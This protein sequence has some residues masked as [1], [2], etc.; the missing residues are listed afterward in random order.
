MRAGHAARADVDAQH[1]YNAGPVTRERI[2][3]ALKATI[4]KADL[5]VVDLDRNYFADHALTIARHPSET[6][7]RM[8]VRVLAFALFAREGLTFTKGLFD[9]DEP[10]LWARNLS[11]EIELWIDLGQPDE[12]RIRRACSRAAHVV[13]LCY[14]GSCDTWWKSVAG[15]LA[16]LTNLNVVQLPAATADALAALAERGMRLQCMIQD[17]DVWLS[18]DQASVQVKRTILKPTD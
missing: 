17:G 12:A 3:M 14:A 9:V 13:V 7:A 10:E 11:G 8:M 2:A 4:Y 15:K 6:D 5:Q 1:G 18:S 16:R